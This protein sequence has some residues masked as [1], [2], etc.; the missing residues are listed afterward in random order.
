MQP[1]GV[2]IRKLSK[3]STNTLSKNFYKNVIVNS[4]LARL[5]GRG[6]VYNL[7]SKIVTRRT[8]ANAVIWGS[9]LIEL[10]LPKGNLV[11][12]SLP[13]LAS[14]H[15]LLIL[16]PQNTGKTIAPIIPFA[17][18]T[19][20]I[21]GKIICKNLYIIVLV[22]TKDLVLQESRNVQQY[23]KQLRVS[24]IYHKDVEWYKTNILIS[25]PVSLLKKVQSEIISLESVRLLCIHEAQEILSLDFKCGITTIC[26]IKKLLHPNHQTVY[27]SRFAD[28]TLKLLVQSMSKL[29]FR[30]LNFWESQHLNPTKPIWGSYRS[31]IVISHNENLN[32]TV[33]DATNNGS[34][35]QNVPSSYKPD[36]ATTQD[37]FY[38]RKCENVQQLVN[39][40]KKLSNDRFIWNINCKTIYITSKLYY[41]LYRP[42]NFFETLISAC[43]GKRVICFFPTVKLLQFMNLL[44]K[45]RFSNVYMLCGSQSVDKRRLVMDTFRGKDIGLLLTTDISCLG[46]NLGPFDKVIQVG[47]SRSFYNFAS[48]ANMAA[49]SISLFHD[50]D[51]HYIYLLYKNL[52]INLEAMRLDCEKTVKKMVLD[53]YMMASLTLAYRSVMSMY[54]TIAKEF[55]FEKWQVPSLINDLFKSIGVDIDIKITKQFAAR[56]GLLN[57]P[58]LNV[59]YAT[60]GKKTLLAM[61]LGY[62]GY[63]SRLKQAKDVI[64]N[65]DVEIVKEFRP[66]STVND[67]FT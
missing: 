26:K 57:S 3:S 9:T 2:L 65:D 59:D 60:A 56:M 13:S 37:G 42:N 21:K 7:L 43:Q 46:L 16:G 40:Y 47:P 15:D 32:S 6:V 48:R 31:N 23:I 20:L 24:T 4:P 8:K 25:T 1:R 30:V 53:E 67:S 50:L 5:V 49:V 55:K 58:G 51:C 52:G 64:Y 45:R 35:I 12:D 36:A 17:M 29:N 44:I 14:G 18:A 33:L 63:I 38:P 10:K 62:P 28:H 39:Y 11:L 66:L 61:V 54:C 22:P 27:T 34:T 41:I 19:N